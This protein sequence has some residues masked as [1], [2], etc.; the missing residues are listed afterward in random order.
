M[1]DGGKNMISSHM[2]AM[3]A[4]I[5]AKFRRQEKTLYLVGPLGNDENAESD[6]EMDALQNTNEHP[7]IP[8]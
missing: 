4:S 8:S 2:D 6:E 3:D 5:F 1:T 7:N